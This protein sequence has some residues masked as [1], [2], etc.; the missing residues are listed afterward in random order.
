MSPLI[1][2]VLDLIVIVLLAATVFYAARLSMHLK[3]FRE[4]RRDFDKLVGDLSTQIQRAEGAITGLREA[5]KSTGLDDALRE[6]RALTDELQLMTK[7]GDNLAARLERL[8]DRANP[9]AGV[10]PP[11]PMPAKPSAPVRRREKASS[12]FTIR[13]PEFAAAEPPTELQS[14]AERD[15]YRALAGKRGPEKGKRP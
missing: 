14:E 10:T 7:A 9:S 2:T 3:V 4:S 15:L 6:A 8:A 5:T 12:G 13:D 11:P 1:G